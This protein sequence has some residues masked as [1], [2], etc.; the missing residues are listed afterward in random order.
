MLGV[1]SVINV[2]VLPVLLIHGTPT[3][4]TVAISKHANPVTQDAITKGW[5][6]NCGHA[7]TTKE[8]AVEGYRHSFHHRSR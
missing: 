2:D 7:R 3:L 6:S 1:R 4:K 5:Y 8:P